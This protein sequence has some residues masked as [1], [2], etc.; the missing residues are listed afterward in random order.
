MMFLI[1]SGTGLLTFIGDKAFFNVYAGAG[2]CTGSLSLAATLAADFSFADFV[3]IVSLYLARVNC[4]S[5][6]PA[7]SLDLY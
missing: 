4:A 2:A 7:L 6:S 3:S 1:S 5:F